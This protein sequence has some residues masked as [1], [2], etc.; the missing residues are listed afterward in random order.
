MYVNLRDDGAW[1]FIGTDEG[2]DPLT[3]GDWAL[4]GMNVCQQECNV[5]IRSGVVAISRHNTEH[6]TA[7]DPI[8]ALPRA[9]W[10]CWYESEQ[11]TEGG[12]HE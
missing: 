8:Q 12:A 9:F 3:S 1:Y 4:K 2:F 11:K 7:F 10:Q 5:V 6:I